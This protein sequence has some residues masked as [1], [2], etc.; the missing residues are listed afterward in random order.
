MRVATPVLAALGAASYAVAQSIISSGPLGGLGALAG[1]L[2]LTCEAA[3]LQLAVSNSSLE[4]C[5]HVTALEPLLTSNGSIIPILDEWM[6]DLCYMPP[7]SNDTLYNASVAISTACSADLAKYSITNATFLAAIEEYT[8]A[9]EILCLKTV[10]P[11]TTMNATIPVTNLTYSAYN[12]TNGTF[13]VTS[14]LTEVSSYLGTNLTVPYIESMVGMAGS[15][16]S[17]ALMM[18]EMLPPS[19]ICSDCIFAAADLLFEEYPSLAYV[20]VNQT[21]NTT[22]LQYLNGLCAVEGLNAT[23]NGTLPV[24][25][26]ESAFNSSYP[27]NLTI[28]NITYTPGNYSILPPQFNFTI[29]NLTINSSSFN[30]SF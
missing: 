18:L 17:S 10:N 2:S 11:Y 22:V 29:G 3:L 30:T 16:N 27:Y 9:R 12:V 19:T 21:T 14:V 28:G 15:A 23:L 26:T 13:C 1:T 24:N 5:L 20:V 7:C 25:I 8:L 6:T 4:Q